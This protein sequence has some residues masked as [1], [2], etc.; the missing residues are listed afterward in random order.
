MPMGMD[1]QEDADLP[2]FLNPMILGIP[3]IDPRLFVCKRPQVIREHG[4]NFFN[5][6]Q[7]EHIL[8][9][10]KWLPKHT[11]I[12]CAQVCT[13]FKSIALDHTLWRRL[14]L[15]GR[16]LQPGMLGRI[17]L[18]GAKYLRLS[19][20]DI[21]GPVFSPS[22]NYLPRIGSNLIFLD[23]S[24]ADCTPETLAELFSVCRR[25]KKVSLEF[26]TLTDEVFINLSDNLSL[27]TLNLSMAV[28]VS[29]NG[30]GTL[31]AKCT[32]LHHLNVAWTHMSQNCVQELVLKASPR[33]ESLNMAGHRRGQVR[34]EEV[35]TLCMRLHHL[36]ELDLSDC[37]EITSQSLH[38][39]ATKLRRLT[40]LG[41]SRCYGLRAETYEMLAAMPQLQHLSLFGVH[42]DAAMGALRARL[43]RVTVNGQ[44]FTT[45]ARPTVGLRR[46]SIWTIRV[47]DS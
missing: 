7:D 23:L 47:R 27:D 2:M 26:L 21:S 18:R 12:K 30:L 38:A 10:F 17:I 28:G 29:A 4:T 46:T 16:H 14:D 34:D 37:T 24:M 42:D 39:I 8:Q 32:E 13:R 43:P 33:L 22:L 11:L 25:L 1:D 31:L 45:V 44:L 5:T 40:V 3:P 19:K 20:A 15:N 6:L 41:L 9:I 36:K 35:R